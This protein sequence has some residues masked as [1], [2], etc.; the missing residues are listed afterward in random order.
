MSDL[1]EKYIQAISN[2]ADE[3]TLE[4]VRL[5]AVGKRAKSA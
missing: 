2:A 4:E 1:R 3:A 5:A